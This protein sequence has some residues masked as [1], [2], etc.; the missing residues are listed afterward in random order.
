MSRKGVNCLALMVV[1]KVIMMMTLAAAAR[2]P[3]DV[4]AR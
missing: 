1:M 3:D 4:D 2:G